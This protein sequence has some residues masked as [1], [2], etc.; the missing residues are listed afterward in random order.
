MH[1]NLKRYGY[2]LN[3]PTNRK[4][5]IIRRI[6]DPA[7]KEEYLSRFDLYQYIP[8][9]IIARME[10]QSFEKGE[11][12]CQQGRDFHTVYFLLD[13]RLQTDGLHPN[14]KQ[15]V[16]SFDVPFSI[17]GELE[18]FTPQQIVANVQAL[19]DSLVF[20][21]PVEAVREEGIRDP[22]FLLFFIRYLTQKLYLDVPLIMQ[23]SLPAETRLARYLLFDSRREGDFIRMEK[24]DS[25]AALLNISVR[26]INRILLGWMRAGIIEKRNKRVQILDRQRLQKLAE[27]GT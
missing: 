21:L 2:N 27:N 14:G 4:G 11:Y 16:F 7:R 19:Q 6:S 1:L 12:L 13:G 5:Q 15:V 8:E 22:D 23:A 20:A 17:I 3:K 25:I 10:L 9:R 26:H 24:R 18:L